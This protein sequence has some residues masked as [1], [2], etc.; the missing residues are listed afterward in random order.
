MPLRHYRV[1][2]V[3]YLYRDYS[4]CPGG[5]PEDV[6]FGLIGVF[7]VNDT[8]EGPEATEGGTGPGTL[9]IRP[10]FHGTR[11]TPSWTSA[12]GGVGEPSCLSVVTG[13]PTSVTFKT[14]TSACVHY[15]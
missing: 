4:I 2:Q 6:E 1:L 8:D 9:K 3:T 7:R 15:S 14:V 10:P 11:L 12:R 13:L 5:C